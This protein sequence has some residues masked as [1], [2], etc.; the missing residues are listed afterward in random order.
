[1]NNGEITVIGRVCK[2]KQR[3]QNS[4]SVNRAT[5]ER[6]MLLDCGRETSRPPP[7]ENVTNTTDLASSKQVREMM[8]LDHSE[9]YH[10]R[11]IH[12]TEQASL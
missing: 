7:F 9:I 2:D 12:G 5:V 1:M 4:A 8:E 6:Q 3:T 11:K 10:S